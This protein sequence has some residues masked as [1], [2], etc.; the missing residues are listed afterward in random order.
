MI[1]GG[2]ALYLAALTK[3]T[4]LVYLLAAVIGLAFEIPGQAG[5]DPRHGRAVGPRRNGPGGLLVGGAELRR[6]PCW[7]SRATP[8]TFASWWQTIRVVATADP[9][10]FVLTATGIA[11]WS[12]GPR[13]EPRLIA[14]AVLLLGSALIT[15]AKRG[16]ADNYFLGM[17]SVAALAAGGLWHELAA[18]E[19]R[20]RVWHLVAAAAAL[21]CLAPA[22]GRR[23][24][25]QS[26][27]SSKST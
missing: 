18:P 19:R 3:Q 16:S 8:A 17:R 25:T 21:A 23:T 15:C 7:A 13:R 26:P 4:A 14:L 12:T 24:P 5:G 20:A 10:F 2:V 11:F 1:A 22:P 6:G 27:S 9:E